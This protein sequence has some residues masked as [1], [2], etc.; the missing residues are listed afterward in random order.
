MLFTPEAF[1]YF[2]HDGPEA[3]VPFPHFFKWSAT[4]AALAAARDSFAIA[5][6]DLNYSM[7]RTEQEV[8]HYFW[9]CTTTDHN[10]ALAL[11]HHLPGQPEDSSSRSTRLTAPKSSE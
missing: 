2:Q 6:Q 4:A 9:E 3:I 11:K 5:A 10:Y 1:N 8:R 7:L